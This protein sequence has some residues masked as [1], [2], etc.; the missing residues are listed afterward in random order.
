MWAATF[1]WTT[2]LAWRQLVAAEWH[3]GCHF[4]FLVLPERS[5]GTYFD[6]DFS[7]WQER[8]HCCAPDPRSSQSSCESTL[9]S[10]AVA[11]CPLCQV[12]LQ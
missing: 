5:D 7:D 3:A 6:F 10:I 4:V 11:C 1:L 8:L 12:V 9:Q 2:A